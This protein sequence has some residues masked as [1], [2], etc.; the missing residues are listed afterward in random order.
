[1]GV[2]FDLRYSLKYTN[3]VLFTSLHPELRVSVH[4]NTLFDRLCYTMVTSATIMLH[5]KK[6]D[7]LLGTK[8]EEGRKTTEREYVKAEEEKCT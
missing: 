1:M 4:M 7:G 3:C 8:E 6:V 2:F 5:N